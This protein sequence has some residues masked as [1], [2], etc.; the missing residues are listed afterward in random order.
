MGQFDAVHSAAVVFADNNVL[1]NV[2]K[3]AGKVTGVGRFKSRIGQTLTSTVGGGEVLQ[4]REAFAERRRNRRFNDFTRGLG[5]QAAHASQLTHLVLV[6]TSTRIGHHIDRVEA[7][8]FLLL[9]GLGIGKHVVGYFLD[10]L[11]R[12]VLCGLGP[13][14]DHLVVLFSTGDDT[15]AVLM[16][17]VVNLCLRGS[18]NVLFAFRNG[19]VF[20]ADGHARAGGEFVTHVLQTVAQNDRGLD[21]AVAVGRAHETRNVL[22]GEHAVDVFEAQLFGQ[23]V[24]HQ[25][26][27]GGRVV[28][29]TIGHAHLDAGMQRNLSAVIGGF[30][31]PGG[32]EAHAFALLKAALGGHVVQ[33][34]HDILRRHDDR[35]A[36]G[37]RE[38]VV[39]AHHEH[40]AFDLRFHRK[41]NVHGHL[42][43]VKVGVVGRADE[44]V[45]TDGLAFYQQGFKGLNAQTV[46]GRGAVEQNGVLAHHF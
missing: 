4:H 10:H 19:E 39:G 37:G 30:H 14:V 1:H 43:T 41:G 38:N 6:T 7:L 24:A 32:A 22:L 3:A 28:H 15:V 25:H 29:V 34:K 31:F 17:D 13:H 33:T 27:A 35:A 12:D 46:Q 42:V 23:D 40:A 18:Q 44:R 5:H 11:R 36:V 9:A 20:H 45:Q 21:A 2:D 8:V 16:F 26:A